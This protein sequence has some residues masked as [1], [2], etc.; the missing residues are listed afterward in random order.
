[1]IA[2][3]YSLFLCAA[4]YGNQIPVLEFGRCLACFSMIFG[5]IYMSFP[6]AIIGN[7][8]EAAWTHVTK[9]VEERKV[10]ISIDQAMAY[11]SHVL[12]IVHHNILA[13]L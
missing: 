11:L 13:H 10:I 7:E 3:V 2:N 4:G 5:A 12:I 6:L 1:M 8:Y 9:L